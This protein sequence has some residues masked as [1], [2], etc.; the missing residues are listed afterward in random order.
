MSMHMIGVKQIFLWAG[1]C[2]LASQIFHEMI[3]I[4]FGSTL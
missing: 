3:T 1:W 2:V 4:C